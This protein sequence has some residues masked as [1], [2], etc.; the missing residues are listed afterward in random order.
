MPKL[1][2]AVIKTNGDTIILCVSSDADKA[3]EV[4][5]SFEE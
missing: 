5:A 1:E 3:K 2:K 4:I